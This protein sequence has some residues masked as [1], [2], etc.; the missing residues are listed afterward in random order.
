MSEVMNLERK[1]ISRWQP[2]AY[3]DGCEIALITAADIVP[4]VPGID[5]WDSW[6]LA[7]EDGRTAIIGGRQYWFFL[8]AP[9]FPDPGQRHDVARIRLASKGADG[10]RDHGNAMP[11]GFSPGAREWAGSAVL[12]DDG[13]SVTLFF[14]AAGRRD[15][16]PS[17]EQRLFATNGVLGADGPG[18]WETP[19]EIVAPDG[20]RYM[21]ACDTDAR[22]GMI[23]AFRDPAWFR[24]PQTGKCHVLF[25]ASAGW[26]DHDYNGTV[27]ICTLEGD[28]WVLGDPL[29]EAVGVN[30]ELERA[31]VIVRDGLY[32]L[33]W[34]TQ[35]HTFAPDAHA[36]PNGLYAAVADN[37]FGPWTPVNT[38]GLVAGNPAS[39]PT[40][41]YSWWVT[42][43]GEVWSFID[44]W[45]MQGRTFASHPEVL[46]AQFGG[47]A[48][49]VF[50][51]A[52]AGNRVTIAA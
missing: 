41:G 21:V 24:D 49:P 33:F 19:Y 16:A 46:R 8:S 11:D 2:Q 45:G 4:V 22:P 13:R 37:L 12:H 20:A 38:G 43:E 5:L 40:Q 48:A 30:N 3:A 39:E 36:G 32:Y 28:R 14:T 9:C 29:L 44:H 7:H 35:R 27:G 6:P 47:T 23:K 51:L 50:R 26:S 34:S 18:G 42:G 31:H 1:S 10:W 25:T 17:F 52:F 15:G